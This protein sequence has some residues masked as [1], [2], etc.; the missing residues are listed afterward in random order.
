MGGAMGWLTILWERYHQGTQGAL[1]SM[2]PLQRL[3]LACRA[4]WFYAGKL[5]WPAN[6]IFSY[7]RWNI[8]ASDPSAYCWLLAAAA[9]GIMIVLTRRWLGRAVEVALLFFAATLAPLLGFIMLYTFR[10]SF[11]ADHYQYLACIGPLA[12]AAAGIETASTLL[13]SLSAGPSRRFALNFRRRLPAPGRRQAGGSTALPKDEATGPKPFLAAGLA[14]LLG[15]LTWRQCGQ[16]TNEETLWRTT[17]A[18]NPASW[19]AWENLANRLRDRGALPEAILDYQNALELE[20]NFAEGHNDLGVALA[21]SGQVQKAIQEYQIALRL[22]PT[23]GQAHYNLGNAWVH[24]GRLAQAIAQY[25]QALQSQPAFVDARVNLGLALLQSG[26]NKEAIQSWEQVLALEPDFPTI[27]SRL[28]WVLATDPDLSVRNGPRAVALA[29][30]A[31]E[32]TAGDDPAILYTLAAAYAEAGRYPEA[33]ATAQTALNQAE[34]AKN[35]ALSAAL[36]E[37]IRLI[38]ASRPIRVGAAGLPGLP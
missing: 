33:N 27:L 24:E 5:L 38:S 18:K 11:V 22:E 9:L 28:A 4:L 31:K 6:L 23:F 36:K 26:K 10:Y 1:F 3:L 19:M 12:L 35:A 14:I 13:G 20:P 2:G 15:V 32:L 7:P 21:D 25:R 16:Y 34:A 29:L 30:R 37:A 17:V 8:S